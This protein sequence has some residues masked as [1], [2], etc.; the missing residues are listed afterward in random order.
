LVAPLALLLVLFVIV[1]IGSVVL[2]SFPKGDRLGS[3]QQV[4]ASNASVKAFVRTL[5]IGLLVTLITVL[6][7]AVLA[8]YLRTMRS[9]LLKTLIWASILIPFW[10]G[11]VIK[12]YTFVILLGRQGVV[13][14]MLEMVGIIDGP[15][16][17]LYTETAVII[18]MVYTMLPYAVLPMFA[19]M[20]SID[21]DLVRA[22][23][24]L[25]ASRTRAVSS[26]VLPLATPG[27]MA[28]GPIVF[29]ISLGFYVT[30]VILGGA[31]TPF[32]A[33]LIQQDIFRRFDYPSAAATSTLLL[34]AAVV[35]IIVSLALVGR[36]RLERA[37]A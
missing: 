1:P 25:G 2:D 23:Q 31:R 5:W 37:I 29:V 7:G 20:T 6:T 19:V 27:I 22:A 17:L 9:R 33:T 34:A 14:R 32:V 26:V 4:F 18:G 36:Q 10:M 11:I 24:S 21:S 35:T 30:P 8:W 15:M 16:D 28:S 13:N 12:N 3:Y